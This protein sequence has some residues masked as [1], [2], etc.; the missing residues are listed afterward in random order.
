MVT[1]L[2]LK[3]GVLTADIDRAAEG[4]GDLRVELNHQVSLVRKLFVS[5][6]DRLGD[7]LPERLPDHR[8]DHI[9]DPLP[10]QLSHVALVGQVRGDL[11][12]QLE[13]LED[14]LNREAG[15]ERDMKVLG[16]FCFDDYREISERCDYLQRFLPLTRSLR[17]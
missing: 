3:K 5:L 16:C 6:L 4:L 13:L 2:K 9:D 17:K 7:P 11:L 15:V 10:W 1:L 8:V 12:V 14:V